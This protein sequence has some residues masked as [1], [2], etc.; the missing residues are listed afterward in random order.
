MKEEY[1]F[2]WQS[3]SDF[4]DV[5]CFKCGSSRI[6]PVCFEDLINEHVQVLIPSIDVSISL[7]W[8]SYFLGFPRMFPLSWLPRQ[9]RCRWRWE[10]T[11]SWALAPS[12]AWPYR[13]PYVSLTETTRSTPPPFIHYYSSLNLSISLIRRDSY[14]RCHVVII[15]FDGYRCLSGVRWWSSALGVRIIIVYSL[16]FSFHVV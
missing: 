9:C 8:M 16:M 12:T 1:L 5:R 7:K 13:P 15:Y 3:A 14:Y 6:K 11:G 4:M 2:L 10:V